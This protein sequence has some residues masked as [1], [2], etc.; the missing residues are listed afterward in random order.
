M[1]SILVIHQPQKNTADQEKLERV[2]EKRPLLKKMLEKS[3]HL[4]LKEFSGENLAGHSQPDPHRQKELL[5]ILKNMLT[6]RLGTQVASEVVTQME[7]LYYVSTA[8]HHGTINSGLSVSSNLLIASGYPEDPML[9]YLVVLSCA[10]ITQK[11]EDYPR[12]LLF[13]EDNRENFPLVKLPILPHDTRSSVLY[14]FRA[15]TLQEIVKAEESL[16]KQTRTGEVSEEKSRVLLDL[17]DRIYKRPDTL[18][19]Q[20]ACEQFTTI[21]HEMWK[22]AFPSPHR[23]DLI[24]LDQE[25]LIAELLIHHHMEQNTVLHKVIFDPTYEEKLIRPVVNAMEPYLRQG[26]VGDS[27]FWA[28]TKENNYRE[29]LSKEGN[30]LVSGDGNIRVPLT[31]EGIG[32]AL[33][34]GQIYPNIFL[35]FLVLHLYYG[36]NCLGGFNQMHY[37]AAMQKAYNETAIDPV[38]SNGKSDLYNYGMELIHLE[39]GP[40]RTL[41]HGLDLLLYKDPELWEK[42]MKASEKIT[43]NEL[44]G[45]S[46]NV[47]HDILYPPGAEPTA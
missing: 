40:T 29:R 45:A 5:E 24:Y 12:G 9:K 25:G 31:P 4:T 21:T 43:L 8:D 15:F 33:K 27:L 30:E 42:V 47:V 13:H 35:C 16:K 23:K 46:I 1:D 39:N 2:F 14:G 18:N 11:N 7:H 44:F 37:L 34:A 22:E 38:T 6:V 3:G 32:R 10:G 26:F 41:I 19:L 28:L 20:L 36:L 17:L